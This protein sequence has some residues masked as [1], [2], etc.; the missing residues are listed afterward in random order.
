[1]VVTDLSAARTRDALAYVRKVAGGSGSSFYGPMLKLTAH[2]RDGMLALYAFCREA[3]DAVD[4]E[5][6]PEKAAEKLAFWRQE[7]ERLY[8]KT[9]T[10]PVTIALLDT[11]ARFTLPQGLFMEIL[12]G[13]EMDRSGQMVHPDKATLERYCYHVASCVGLLSI[14]IFGYSDPHAR[15]FAIHLGHA[16]Q[17]TNILRDIRE[18]AGYGRCYLPK[19]LLEAHGLDDV[20]LEKLPDHPALPA[21][22][23]VLGLEARAHFQQADAA[24]PHSDAATLRPARM[25]QQIYVRYLDKMAAARWHLPARKLSLSWW[26]KLRVVGGL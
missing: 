10:H 19:E 12:D 3:D 7:I 15:E 22:C 13:F 17:C 5:P 14:E 20:P 21:L 1:M 9:P 24:F 8:Q 6:D 4:L 25:M 18:D 23:A 2:K 26:D 11:V 16:M